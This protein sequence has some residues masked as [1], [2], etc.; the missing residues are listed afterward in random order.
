MAQPPPHQYRLPRTHRLSGRRL[1]DAVFAARIRKHIG[2]L[3]ILTRP[4]DL[5]HNRLGLSVPRR[6]GT[7]VQ[8]N[9]IKRLIREA[10]RL[11]Q[12][13]L[14]PGYDIVVAVRPHNAAT[15]E[16]YQ[17][18][19]LTALRGAHLQWQRRHRDDDRK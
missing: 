8:R 14:P 2:P 3:A 10:F 19:L 15:L 5:P 18:M 7:A 11:T 1:F 9:R 16:D 12:H 6:V 17:R 4:N 13:D